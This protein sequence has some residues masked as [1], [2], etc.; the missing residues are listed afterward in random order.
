MNH[1]YINK[2]NL[3]DQYVLGKLTTDQVEEFEAHFVDCPECVDQLNIS[4]SFINDLKGF[5]VEETLLADQRHTVQTHQWPLQRL[6]PRRF[7]LAIAGACVVLAVGLA[8]FSLRRLGRLDGE[9]RKTKEDAA[10]ISQKYQET[11]ETAA[12]SEKRHREANQDLAQRL[13]EL[14]KQLKTE[15]TPN[16]G[17]QSLIRGSEA[18][19]INFP[20]YALVSVARGQVPAPVEIALPATSSRF[21]LSIPVEDRKDFSSYRLMILDQRGV[22]VF[23]RSGFKPDAYHALSLSLNSNF[24]SPGPYDLKVEGLTPPNAWSTVGTYP[25]RI[26]RRR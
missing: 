16:K 14:E 3:I 19:E 11:L 22:T 17:Q 12:E 20:I 13:D 5:A 8:F 15:G 23:N 7:W 25:F 9:L 4:R 26:V 10:A 18:P 21:A 1:D 6:M 24:L 2:F